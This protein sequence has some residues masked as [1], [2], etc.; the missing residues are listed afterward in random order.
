MKGK[1]FSII[2]AVLFLIIIFSG[3]TENEDSSLITIQGLLLSER[4]K[5]D[6]LMFF[7]AEDFTRERFINMWANQSESDMQYY[8][9]HTYVLSRNG[10]LILDTENYEQEYAEFDGMYHY[11]DEVKIT[12]QLG[13][14]EV[15]NPDDEKEEQKS[16][17]I[18]SIEMISSKFEI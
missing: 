12:G 10:E 1:L 9:S 3:C 11:F 16:I 6:D 17:D 8:Q 14:I 18:V 4:V 15:T 2:L 13:T 5:N 7:I